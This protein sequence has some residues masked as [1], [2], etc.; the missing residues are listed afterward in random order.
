MGLKTYDLSFW[1]LE[2][3][4]VQPHFIPFL[5]L[6][7]SSG[8]VY[9]IFIPL[10]RLFQVGLCHLTQVPPFFIKLCDHWHFLTCIT[11]GLSMCCPK[12]WAQLVTCPSPFERWWTQLWSVPSCCNKIRLTPNGPPNLVDPSPHNSLRIVDHQVYLLGL[13][14]SLGTERSA[15][16]EFRPHVLL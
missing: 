10:V 1:Q 5:K 13:S 12:T 14:I 8:L 6:H 16:L 11:W 15:H 7:L 3:L 9:K 2:I 4:N